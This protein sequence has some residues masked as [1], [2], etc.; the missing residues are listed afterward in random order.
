MA[1]IVRNTSRF[2][3][4]DRAGDRSSTSDRSRDTFQGKGQPVA[5][6]RWRR[7]PRLHMMRIDRDGELQWSPAAPKIALL[8]LRRALMLLALRSSRPAEICC[9]AS[10]APPLGA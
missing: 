3:D 5:F 4:D 10:A 9:G 7:E 2:T 6:R 1:E 8:L